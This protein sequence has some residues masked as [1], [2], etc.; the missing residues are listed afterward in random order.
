[1]TGGHVRFSTGD[2]MPDDQQIR[3]LEPRPSGPTRPL[4][5]DIVG[6]RSATGRF[7]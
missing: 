5:L 6:P 2:R 1:M 3:H 4:G 7:G